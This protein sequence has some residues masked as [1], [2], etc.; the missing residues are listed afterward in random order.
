MKLVSTDFLR[1]VAVPHLVPCIASLLASQIIRSGLFLLKC[2]Y[3]A[4]RF[5]SEFTFINAFSC[6]GVQFHTAS[7]FK[8][9]QNGKHVYARSGMNLLNWL[10]APKN[11]LNSFRFVGLNFSVIPCTFELIGEMPEF[12]NLNPN[13][14]I[15]FPVLRSYTF[16]PLAAIRRHQLL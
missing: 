12:V 15:Q 3:S 8:I 9:E 10:T 6:S 4:T 16:P 1:I 11:D 7:F 5:T 2:V 13:Q 14:T